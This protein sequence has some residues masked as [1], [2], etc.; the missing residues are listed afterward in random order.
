MGVPPAG[1]DKE[2]G[3]PL[4]ADRVQKTDHGNSSTFECL[5]ITR[6]RQG[7]ETA[8]PRGKSQA[9]PPTG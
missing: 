9:L 7:A 6:E 3:W 5:R 2:T 8:H 4:V 1:S